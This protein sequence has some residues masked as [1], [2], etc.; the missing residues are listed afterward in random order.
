MRMEMKVWIGPGGLRAARV[1]IVL[2]ATAAVAAPVD[3]G[4]VT[5]T[6]DFSA[7]TFQVGSGPD[8]APVDPVIGQ[9]TLTFD[10]TVAVTNSIAN[11]A[12]NSLNI[13]LGSAIAFSYDPTNNNGL[14]AIGGINAGADT[15]IYDPS[16]NDFWLFITNFTIAPVF[17]QLGYTQTAVSDDNLFYT[18]NH[19]G[20][21]TVKE[22][23]G[24]VPEP[25]S[26]A[27][28]ALG[29]AGALALGRRR[30]E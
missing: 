1:L 2:L 9:V 29:M 13:A 10:P 5:Y 19:T 16:T 18:L 27:L 23:S 14:L 6:V 20:S 22:D 28:A 15:I 11:I 17:D 24:V 12:L 8:P 25:S 30:R 4:L 21:A 3:A 26:L 7:N